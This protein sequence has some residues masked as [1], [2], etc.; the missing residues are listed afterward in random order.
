MPGSAAPIAAFVAITQ[1]AGGTDQN[2][3]QSEGPQRQRRMAKS[4]Y[5]VSRC[6]GAW[7]GPREAFFVG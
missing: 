6:K 1:A 5:F 2:P 3:K 7:P 4:G